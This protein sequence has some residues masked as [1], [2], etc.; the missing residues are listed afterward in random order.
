MI[1]RLESE[2][3]GAPESIGPSSMGAHSLGALTADQAAA[4]KQKGVEIME[5]IIHSARPA[6]S[7]HPADLAKIVEQIKK[8]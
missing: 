3:I 6:M 2:S 4:I 7:E 1:E 5:N 8:Q